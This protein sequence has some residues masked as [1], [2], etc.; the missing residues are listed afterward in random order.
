MHLLLRTEVDPVIAL[1]RESLLV[2]LSYKVDLHLNFDSSDNS[3][4]ISAIV[5]LY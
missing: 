1:E 5:K 3:D 2:L 4:D